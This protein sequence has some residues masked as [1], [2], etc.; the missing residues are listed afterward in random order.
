M[1]ESLA[2]FVVAVVG[3]GLPLARRW[4]E[5]TLHAAVAL[6]TGIFLGAVFLHLLPSLAHLDL[7]GAAAEHADEHAGDHTGHVH[8]QGKELALWAFVLLG[9]LGVYLVEALFLRTYDKDDDHRHRAVGYSAL[10]GLCLH[11]GAEGV[12]LAAASEQPELSGPVFLA[13]LSHKAFAGFSLTTV[14]QLAG[15]PRPR[16]ALLV[17][18]FALVTPI[19]MWIGSTLVDTASSFGLAALTAVAA[20]TF[21]FVSLVELLPEVF[22]HREDSLVKILLL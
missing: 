18:G 5:R 3:G 15:M 9:A 6:A 11:S 8:V 2:L 10:L 19:G 12:A 21:L 16:I 13:I 20:G 22:H 14:F 4:N 17:L 7:G 1:L